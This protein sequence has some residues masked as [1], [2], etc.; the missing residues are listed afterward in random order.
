MSDISK[1]I[2]SN[3]QAQAFTQMQICILASQTFHDVIIKRY[4]NAHNYVFLLDTVTN[5]NLCLLPLKSI[6]Q[7]LS[8]S[9]E[10][11]SILVDTFFSNTCIHFE[12]INQQQAQKKNMEKVN[13]HMQF[14]LTQGIQH[15][16]KMINNKCEKN[17]ALAFSSH[18]SSILL[19]SVAFS[20]FSIIT[21]LT[22]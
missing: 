4:L 1:S 9:Q 12:G 8:S 11:V 16:F 14:K 2:D 13:R 7:P 3:T 10:P 21:L 19:R 18:S 17:Y 5:Y 20:K 6:F 22:Q 15:K